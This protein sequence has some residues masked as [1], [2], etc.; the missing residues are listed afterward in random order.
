MIDAP[1]FNQILWDIT[2]ALG[3]WFWVPF[4]AYG[5]IGLRLLYS[6]SPAATTLGRVIRV[7]LSAAFVS[8]VFIPIFN[9]LGAYIFHA[10]AIGMLLT[11]YQ[12]YL[13]CKAAG[14]IRPAEGRTVL[15]R[16]VSHMMEIQKR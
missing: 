4:V 14:L 6:L 2:N 12:L 10:V 7:I 11:I 13:G 15:E 3:W 1:S 8:M 9:G 16:T 5:L